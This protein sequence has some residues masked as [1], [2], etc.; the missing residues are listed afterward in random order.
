MSEYQCYEFVALDHP[1]TSQQMGQL[2]A[3]STRAEISAT[4][5]WNEYH[6]G[7]LKADPADLLARYFD[8]HFYFANWGTRRFM[9]RLPAG[10][11]TVSGLK[12]YF[13]GHH[14][15]L[16]KSGGFVVLD[17]WSND[18]EE[19]EEEQVFERGRL[20]ALTPIRA[21][22]LQGDLRPAYLAWLGSA[23]AGEVA[24]DERE[25]PVPEG[26]NHLP[27]ALESLVEVLRV[28]RDLLAAAAE[29]SSAFS[30]DANTLRAW[31][32]ARPQ[33]EKDR[34]LL[35]AAQ[36]PEEAIGAQLLS[37]FRQEHLR[38][39][40]SSPRTVAQLRARAD[41]LRATRQ[42]T[43]AAA[44]ARAR[45]AAAR[46]RATQLDR[47]AGRWQTAWLELD[48]RVGGREY[49]KAIALA[50]DLRDLAQRDGK[51]AEFATRFAALKKVHARRRGFFDAF[52]P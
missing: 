32:K 37:A 10:R 7:D 44:R 21:L 4:R 28:D 31:V 17:L 18:E 50:V 33:A 40:T 52:K 49:E 35:H 48:Q 3:I 13:P 19:P 20:A 14:A 16:K 23:H 43:E 5:F 22:L 6:W 41:Q 11:V 30:E 46:K 42:A 24:G 36:H 1:L 26:L 15:R 12:P 38:V 25:P 47:L 45:A 27:A 8:V 9:L 51:S 29:A 2:R 34:W 39:A